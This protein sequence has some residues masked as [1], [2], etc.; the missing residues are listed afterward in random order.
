MNIKKETER[1][2]EVI[3]FIDSIEK[4]GID[5]INIDVDYSIELKNKSKEIV[6]FNKTTLEQLVVLPKKL[7]ASDYLIADISVYKAISEYIANLG[8]TMHK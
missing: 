2:K 4:I 6:L 1:F 7:N 5:N 8:S 3:T